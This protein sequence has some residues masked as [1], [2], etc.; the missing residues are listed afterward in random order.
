MRPE[1]RNARTWCRLYDPAGARTQDL[2][3]KR[4]PADS[5]LYDAIAV[6][7]ARCDDGCEAVCSDTRGASMQRGSL[8][9]HPR[10]VTWSGRY[11]PK[12]PACKRIARRELPLLGS[13][14]DSSDPESDRR[15]PDT[16]TKHRNKG[17]TRKRNRPDTIIEQGQKRSQSH[18]SSHGRCL[19]LGGGSTTV[20]GR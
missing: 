7:S 17:T 4:C 10:S 3:I 2:R 9:G 20:V 8:R 18:G 6:D 5:Q 16:P 11:D 12:C 15:A 13:N 14:Q 1:R 19:Q